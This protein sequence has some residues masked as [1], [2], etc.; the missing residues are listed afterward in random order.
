MCSRCLR[1]LGLSS[2]Q[3]TLVQKAV[4]VVRTGEGQ[5]LTS[6]LTAS[7][8]HRVVAW[9]LAGPLARLMVAGTRVA[10]MRRDWIQLKDW[11]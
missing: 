8:V 5:V 7:L 3:V 6:I 11:M 10:G 9:R 1:A 2:F 4:V